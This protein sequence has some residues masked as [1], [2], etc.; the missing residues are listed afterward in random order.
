MNRRTE[1]EDYYCVDISEVEWEKLDRWYGANVCLES[2]V[3]AEWNKIR[4]TIEKGHRKTLHL[5]VPTIDCMTNGLAPGEVLYIGVTDERISAAFGLNIVK[6]LGIDKREK[7]LVFNAGRG[8]YAYARGIL[9]LSAEVDEYDLRDGIELTDDEIGRIEEQ[10]EKI[11]ASDISIV[12]TPYISVESISEEVLRLKEE[13]IPALI[14]IDN[15]RF[16]TTRKNCR[17]RDREYRHIS[18]KLRKLA[19]DTL[20]PIVVMGPLSKKR[21]AMGG[22]WPTAIDMPADKLLDYFDK[23]LMVHRSETEGKEV[24]LNVSSIK[25]P[26]GWYGYKKLLYRANYNEL[27]EIPQIKQ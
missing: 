24:C 18:E 16:L 4:K 6:N 15:L 8:E 3:L 13:E 1:E 5:A 21:Q 26:N 20:V 14:V 25:N 9:S 10:I 23:I 12:N 7:L 22:F 2:V 11:K 27:K 19:K 17:N